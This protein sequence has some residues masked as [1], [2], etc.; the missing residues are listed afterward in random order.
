MTLL[1]STAVS[2]TCVPAAAASLLGT[3]VVRLIATGD[4]AVLGLT[5]AS[6]PAEPAVE[7]PGPPVGHGAP[8]LGVHQDPPALEPQP[9]R[10]PVRVLH[11]ALPVELDEGVPPGLSVP[12]LHDGHGLDRTESLEL[13]PERSLVDVVAQPAD[14]EGLVRVR[15]RELRILLRVPALD[16]LLDPRVVLLGLLGGP[17]GL[18]LRLGLLRLGRGRRGIFLGIGEE[19]DVVR[20]AG[21][22]L[23]L[24]WL[25]RGRMIFHGRSRDEQP[26]QRGRQARRVHRRVGRGPHAVHY[27][28]A[29]H[30]RHHRRKPGPKPREPRRRGQA[31]AAGRRW[32]APGRSPRE[33]TQRLGRGLQHDRPSRSDRVAVD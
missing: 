31:E 14:E 28:R 1:R 33:F 10:R 11:V 26:K 21:V 12:V 15:V 17:P 6:G 22:G 23:G 32:E 19:L 4:E 5:P 29:H 16:V 8:T 3:V 2:V 20:D 9:I 13:A 27:W 25:G 30:P 24:L 7:P 18:L